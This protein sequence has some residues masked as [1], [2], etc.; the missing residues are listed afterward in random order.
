MDSSSPAQSGLEKNFMAEGRADDFEDEEV[1]LFHV[2]DFGAQV[3][4]AFIERYVARHTREAQDPLCAHPYT[5]SALQHSWE[6]LCKADDSL[7]RERTPLVHPV[8]LPVLETQKTKWFSG[9]NHEAT[10][11]EAEE[12]D[13]HQMLRVEGS[14]QLV[15]ARIIDRVVATLPYP[16]TM[17]VTPE[18]LNTRPQEWFLVEITKPIYSF[19][20]LRGK[21]APELKELCEEHG[22]EYGN[23]NTARKNLRHVQGGQTEKCWIT[24]P[25]FSEV[26]LDGVLTEFY[27]KLIPFPT[28]LSMCISHLQR[29]V[30]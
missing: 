19:D 26:C 14:E 5:E 6:A 13:D 20:E 2:D 15:V 25:F 3:K 29:Y 28:R 7:H 17:V 4:R 12:E 16:F 8:L 27:G 23:A 18:V 22:V 9:S 30:R 10:G 1:A 24:L 11:E 21:K